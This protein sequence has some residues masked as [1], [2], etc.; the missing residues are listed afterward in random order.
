MFTFT[1]FSKAAC[2]FG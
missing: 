1:N 2:I